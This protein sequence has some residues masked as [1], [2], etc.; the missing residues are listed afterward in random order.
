M[1]WL[2]GSDL[3]EVSKGRGPNP[4]SCT[5]TLT[6]QLPQMTKTEFFLTISIQYQSRQQ[7]RIKKISIKGLLVDPMANSP[8]QHHR[9]CEIAEVKGLI[10]ISCITY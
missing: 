9:N 8:N 5:F 4:V 2:D 6:P 10:S 3:L 1:I 7:I